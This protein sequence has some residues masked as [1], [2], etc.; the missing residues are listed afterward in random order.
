[1]TP[2]EWVMAIVGVV[3]TVAVGTPPIVMEVR[4]RWF[5]INVAAVIDQSGLVRVSI[6]KKRGHDVEIDSVTLLRSGVQSVIPLVSRFPVG[7]LSIP[8]GKNGAKCYMLI[9]KEEVSRREPGID[10]RV[11]RSGMPK[12]IR[13][14]VQYIQKNIVLPPGITLVKV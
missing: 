11:Q 2:I 7:T 6:D 1:M 12:A 4:K 8:E 10:V 9:A 3:A 13:T 5:K 14:K